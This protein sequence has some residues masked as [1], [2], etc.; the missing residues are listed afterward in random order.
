MFLFDNEA[1]CFFCIRVFW[2]FLYPKSTNIMVQF[3]MGVTESLGSIVSLYTASHFDWCMDLDNLALLNATSII[4]QLHKRDSYG[5]GGKGN[6]RGTTLV[7]VTESGITL[8]WHGFLLLFNERRHL[9]HQM[10]RHIVHISGEF[11]WWKFLFRGCVLD[12]FFGVLLSSQP[13]RCFFVSTAAQRRPKI[14]NDSGVF[15]FH[16]IAMGFRSS[17]VKGDETKNAQLKRELFFFV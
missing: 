8:P 4:T 14:R 6:E 5:S 13:W 17:T 9:P 10:L 3:R 1:Q 2:K 15:Q 16:N 12:V 7:T 11:G